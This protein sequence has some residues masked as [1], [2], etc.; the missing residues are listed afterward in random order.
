[1]YMS[2][3]PVIVI[4]YQLPRL[5]EERPNVLIYKSHVNKKNKNYFLWR[6][7]SSDTRSWSVMSSLESSIIR[8]KSRSDAS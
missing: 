6:V 3:L 5:F 4:L 2:H 8:W 1:M 7:S